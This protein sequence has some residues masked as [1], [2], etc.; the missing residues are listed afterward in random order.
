MDNARL[1]TV[2]MDNGARLILVYNLDTM[3]IHSSHE[4]AKVERDPNLFVWFM[5]L[6]ITGMYV[7]TVFDIPATRQPGTVIPF[8]ALTIVHIF[9]HWQL[10]KIMTHRAKII[11]YIL[12][13]GILAVLISALAKN[14]GMSLVIFM[15]LLGEAIGILGLTRRS[16]LAAGYY[17]ALLMVSLIFLSGGAVSGSLILTIILTSVFVILFVAIYMRQIEAR[18]QAQS[19]AA[20]LGTANR[21]LAAYVAQIEDLTLAAERQ[22]MARELHDTLAQGVAGLVL[23]LEA[24]KA[25]L[26]ASRPERAATIIEQALARARG[27]LADSRA[28]IDDLRAVPT[29][30]SEAVRAII[31]RFTWATGI[32][33]KLDIAL[34]D[35]HRIPAGI[36]EHVLS[37]LSEGLTNVTRHAQATEIRVHCSTK[38][39]QFE[40]EIQDNGQGFDP[41]VATRLGHYGLLGM[42]ERARMVGGILSLESGTGQGTR[43]RLSIPFSP[44]FEQASN[45]PGLPMM[46]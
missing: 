12:L 3:S 34:G 28:A 15:G 32:P 45:M 33:C 14:Q 39:H 27:T 30:L 24:V 16:L 5:T 44:T 18:Q 31:E 29:S 26:G 40:L 21:Q 22:R 46:E 7:F 6:V 8:T 35:A 2:H 43:I 11:S 9:L 20:E 10:G 38:D 4:I 13:Q 37:I 19:L 42:R 36:G 23:Q 17:L 1:Y 25:H 41:D